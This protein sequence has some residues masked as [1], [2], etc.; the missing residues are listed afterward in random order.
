[1][2]FFLKIKI[3]KKEKMNQ[4]A[5]TGKY[6]FDLSHT[7]RGKRWKIPNSFFF[8][9]LVIGRYF[10][11]SIFSSRVVGSWGSDASILTWQYPDNKSSLWLIHE[12]QEKRRLK[13]SVG[14]PLLC[15]C[16]PCRIFR[17]WR[18][19][20]KKKK[21]KEGNKR[22]EDRKSTGGQTV[23]HQGKNRQYVELTL[24]NYK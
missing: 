24:G 9:F 18:I 17:N 14:I 22:K 1:M 7:K 12:R 10:V 23:P 4:N 13:K 2:F 3:K 21:I 15:V 11:L 16:V 8:F 20:K 6:R 5:S 19:S